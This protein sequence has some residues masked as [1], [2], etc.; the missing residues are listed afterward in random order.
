MINY[1]NAYNII[2]A[3]KAGVKRDLVVNKGTP[4]EVLNICFEVSERYRKRESE[5]EKERERV[6]EKEREREREKQRKRQ[7]EREREREK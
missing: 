4:G 1:G 2:T 5:R 7:R 3:I 6:R